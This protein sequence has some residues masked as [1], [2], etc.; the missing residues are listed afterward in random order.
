M[1]THGVQV[2]PRGGLHG[3]YWVAMQR[4]FSRK[5]YA[6]PLLVGILL[7]GGLALWCGHEAGRAR[8]QALRE[9]RRSGASVLKA[10]EGS[11]R[12]QVIDGRYR[13]R[14]LHAILEH[15]VDTTGIRFVQLRQEGIPPV[16]AG[17]PPPAFEIDPGT[18]GEK[19][20]G[21]TFLIWRRVRL[22]DC[23]LGLEECKAR[24]VPPG[25]SDLH[26]GD[27]TQVLVLGMSD[28]HLK[29][30]VA[31]VRERTVAML[32]LGVVAISVLVGLWCLRIRYRALAEALA[33]SDARERHLEELR[34]SAAGLAHETKNPLGV[35]RGL[36]QRIA[37]AQ[38]VPGETRHLADAIVNE[39]DTTAARLGDFLSYAGSRDPRPGP[40]DAA[41]V[42]GRVADLLGPDFEQAGVSLAVACEPLVIEADEGM[43]KQ[44][45]VNLVLNALRACRPGGTVRVVLA[46]APGSRAEFRVEDDGE[47]ISPE[48]LPHVFKPYAS[49]REGGHGMGL[50]IV[51]RL[52]ESHGWTIDVRSEPGAGTRMRVAGIRVVGKGAG[53]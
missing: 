50:A 35:I 1:V 3:V 8:D 32:A 36:A 9:M 31:E 34:L 15:V 27:G 51:K 7:L 22:Q 20:A 46:A 2:R 14:V 26:F 45:A 52:V 37:R 47:G 38:D 10:L 44:I 19:L 41:R 42:V 53:S 40:T 30:R 12:S 13:T 39:V 28:G 49:G 23:P 11:V 4:P 29:R 6:F 25:Q 24:V 33:A 5:S 43:L 16:T 48:L 17:L 18:D 21:E